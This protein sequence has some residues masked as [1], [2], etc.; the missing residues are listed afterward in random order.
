VTAVETVGERLRRLRAAKQMSLRRLG[1]AA[2][3]SAAHLSRIENEDRRASVHVI[4]S[5]ARALG[6]SPEYLESGV[7]LSGRE[8]LEFDLA[9][10]ELK[11]RLGPANDEA[12]AAFVA[13]AERADRDGV[14]DIA[15]KARGGAGLAAAGSGQLAAAVDHLETAIAHPV[16]R[17]GLVPDVYTTLATLYRQLDRAEDAVRLCEQALEETHAA[18]RPVHI[19]L[20][21][22]LSHALTDMGR[23]EQAE[24]ALH[25]VEQD[26]DHTDPY[27]R[28]R[29]QWSLARVAAMRDDRRVALR[30]VNAAIRLLKATEDSERLARAH[31]LAAEILLWGGRTLGVAGHLD[32]ARA[33]LGSHASAE[34]RG[35]LGG[36]AA[37]LAARQDR[38]DEARDDADASLAALPEGSGRAPALY[39]RGLT[40]AA[41][42]AHADAEAAFAEALQIKIADKLWRDAAMIAEDRGRA[43]A[44][45]GDDTNSRYWHA[46]AAELGSR[47]VRDQT[48]V[49]TKDTRPTS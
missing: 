8:E 27:A 42:G 34:T 44:Q 26:A 19:V 35:V 38:F 18:N 40:A 37:L 7:E 49:G 36:L 15:A 43:L 31:L 12:A 1:T 22:H 21:T 28:A 30:H 33:L 20:A 16:M 41:F 14:T 11:L 47:A 24:Q 45:T 39:A 3:V 5:L 23:F 13:I 32:S 29:L 9:D 17:P 48:I 2:E 46:Q 10:A 25:E 6:V 4:R